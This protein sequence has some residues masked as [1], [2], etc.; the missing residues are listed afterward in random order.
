MRSSHD[1]ILLKVMRFWLEERELIPNQSFIVIDLAC[2]QTPNVGGFETVFGS[3]PPELGAGG[4]IGK[5][6][7]IDF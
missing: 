5:I 3:A 7:I 1:E 4:R 2:P 6:C